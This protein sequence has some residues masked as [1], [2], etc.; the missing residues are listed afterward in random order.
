MTCPKCECK[1]NLQELVERKAREAFGFGK[2]QEALDL[3][4][5]YIELRSK[6]IA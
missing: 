3:I 4:E 5:A 1:E 6:G 2:T